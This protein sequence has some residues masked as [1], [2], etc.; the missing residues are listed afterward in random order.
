MSTFVSVNLPVTEFCFNEMTV[1]KMTLGLKV[2]F[3]EKAACL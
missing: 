1:T 2:V 3:K